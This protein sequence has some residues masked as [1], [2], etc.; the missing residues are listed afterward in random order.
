MNFGT[1]LKQLREYKNLNQS[2]LAEKLGVSRG[3][4]SDYERNK[5]EPN[6]LA[7]KFISS[8]FNIKIDDLI[9]ENVHLINEIDKN[10]NVHLKYTPNYT[11]NS[12]NL[13]IVSEPLPTYNLPKGIPLVSATAVAGWGN[14]AFALSNQDVI[15]RYEIPLFKHKKVDFLITVEGQ[16][17]V[18]L[19]NHGDIVA[20]AIINQKSFIQYGKAHIIATKDQGIL[21]KR[22]TPGTTDQSLTCLSDNPSYPPFQLPL[23]EVVGMAL[24]VGAIR[25]E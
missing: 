10:E 5:T 2:E 22:I 19:F 15:E 21:L 9:N 14:E 23:T 20:C 13:N 7:L 17:M 16:S 8:F 6:F 11:P 4:I 3:A 24:V 1:K 18:P 25:N 12:E